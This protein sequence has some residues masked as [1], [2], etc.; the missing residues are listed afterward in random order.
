MEF[1]T[2]ST[3]PHLPPEV[4]LGPRTY[5]GVIQ[6]RQVNTKAV[7]YPHKEECVDIPEFRA[8]AF[9]RQVYNLL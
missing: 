1:K 4:A 2:V 9:P 5:R 6:Y 8:N 3:K 7:V